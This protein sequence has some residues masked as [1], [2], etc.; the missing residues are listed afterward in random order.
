MMQTLRLARKVL[1]RLAPYGGLFAGAIAQVLA[2]GLLELA[3]P[4]P[5]KVVVDNVLGGR[6]LGWRALDGLGSRGLLVA[7]CL[8]LVG[9]YALLGLLSVTSNHT[10]IGVGQR[11]VNDFRA[12]L[13][14]HLQRLSLAFHSR[15]Q[16]GDLLYRLTADTFAIQTLTMNG[17]FPL[18]TSAVL[19]GGM[20]VVMLRLDRVLTVVALTVVPLLFLAIAA[21][22]RRITALATDARRK[23]S[24]LWAVAQRTMGAIRVIQAF[25]TEEEEQR[26][27]VG[28]SRDS[29]DAN[30]RLYTFQTVYAAFVNVLIAGGTAAVLWFGATHVLEGSLTVGEVLVFASYLASL[31]AP[32]N[33]VTQTYGLI[34]GARVGAERVFEIL[35]TA[36]DLPDGWRDLARAG[37]Q[38]AITF[39]DVRFGYEPGRLVLKGVDF[40][41]R[42]GARVAIVGAT[43]AGKTTLVSL[44]PRFYD[45]VGGR[46]LLDGADLR[47]IRLRALRQQ[48]AM[49]LQPPLVFPT[50]V[51]DNIAYGRPDATAAA[52][53]E[54]ARL[55]QLEDFLERLPAGFETMVGEGGATLSAGEQLRI[56][57]ARAI[58]RDAPVLVLDEPTAALDAATEARVMQGLEHL[59]AGRTTFVIAHR[60]STVR[61]ADVILVIDDG[62]ILEQ[63]TFAELVARGGA[64]S[65]LH[66]TQFGEETGAG[67]A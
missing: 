39:E 20:L 61:R 54:A 31:Y 7:A 29:L 2:I 4:W 53:R 58:L 13:Y 27:F 51:R 55:A 57:I 46:V 24:A 6:P 22:S 16:V 25:T 66:R 23:E 34:Q 38:G 17:F 64:F 37:V 11:M 48:V 18:L 60:L 52:V 50:S 9:V 45:P 43:G 8:A 62:R 33:S 63:G 49:V 10:T 30:L 21:M 36:P 59:M 12:E 56:T 19:L 44:I 3:K 67:V 47:E 5:L 26:R 15:R 32:I 40:Q 35:E 42:P 1:R 28:S 14:A 65:H 41:A